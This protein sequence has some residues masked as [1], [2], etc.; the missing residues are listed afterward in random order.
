MT[1]VAPPATRYWYDPAATLA[2]V[3]T[4]LRLSDGDVD[5]ARIEALIPAAAGNIDAKVDGDSCDR[6]AAA[7]AVGADRAGDG[8]RRPVPRPVRRRPVRRSGRCRTVPRRTG[9]RPGRRV[10]CR[11]TQGPIRGCLMPSRLADAR[12]VLA[13][14]LSPCAARPRRPVP[15]RP[16]RV[17]APKVWIGDDDG[18]PATI[19]R[20]HHRHPGPVPGRRSSTTA[21]TTPRSPGSTTSSRQQSS[22]PSKPASGF[23]ADVAR[24]RPGPRRPAQRLDVRAAVVTAT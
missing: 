12:S 1:D 13:D 16:G 15:A 18:D 21:P 22:T 6:R 3:F 7:A 5:Q 14:A 24:W 4:M 17:A 19:G 8:N 11:A 2:A 20:P 9:G 23:D 10:A